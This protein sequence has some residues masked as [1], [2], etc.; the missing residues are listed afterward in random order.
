MQ[1]R[2]WMSQWQFWVVV[3]IGIVVLIFAG[4]SVSTFM[5]AQARTAAATETTFALETVAAARVPLIHIAPT[6]GSAG[7]EVVVTGEEWNPGDDITIQLEEPKSGGLSLEV[8]TVFAQFDGRFTATFKYPNDPDWL[9][10]KQV[11][12]KASDSGNRNAVAEFGVLLPTATHTLI[13][14]TK[15]AAAITNAPA[16]I[17]GD[18]NLRFGP[19]SAY[20]V[21]TAVAKDTTVTV[22]GQTQNGSWLFVRLGDGTE[23]WLPRP[24]T[25]FLAVAI[26]VA[27]PPIPEPTATNLPAPVAITDWRGEYWANP[28]LAGQSSL[29]RNDREINFNWGGGSPDTSL[30]VDGFSA[31]WTR[32]VWFE[33]G[34]YRFHLVVD[35]GARAWVDGQIQLDVWADGGLREVTKELSLITGEHS[36]TVTYY[37]RVGD[38]SVRFWWEQVPPTPIPTLTPTLTHTPTPTLVPTA[39]LIPTTVITATPT[40]IPAATAT[41]TATL[42]PTIAATATL[43]P[44]ATPTLTPTLEATATPTLTPTIEATATPTLTPT[45]MVTATLE[46]TVAPIEL[47]TETPVPEPALSVSPK[48]GPADTVVNATLSGFT[49]ETN[50]G[51]YLTTANRPVADSAAAKGQTDANG[52]LE[53]TFTLPTQ[54]PDG[55]PVTPGAIII[56]VIDAEDVVQSTAVITYTP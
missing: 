50:L 41:A 27:A 44:T 53:L 29:I 19:G 23:G 31:R 15:T 36:L 48:S 11:L 47:P 38:A 17:T 7:T 13:P 33:E 2:A 10:L 40:L 22:L 1:V 37:D 14:P 24:F 28:D 26:T 16:R 35:D 56:S 49:A 6:L 42:T 32:V 9:A 46:P 45:A 55:T 18:L 5:N 25:D 43:T 39:T 51:L 3:F 8:A 30:P 54:W 12:V 4:L 34:V 52:N 21:L 20:P